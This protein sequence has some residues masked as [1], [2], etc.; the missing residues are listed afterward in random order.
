[1]TPAGSRRIKLSLQAASKHRNFVERGTNQPSLGH[2]SANARLQCYTDSKL[3]IGVAEELYPA[4][5]IVV[6]KCI[7]A[8]MQEE[9]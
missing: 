7:Y 1:M 5:G 8:R 9:A 4:V 6:K 3:T 2:M